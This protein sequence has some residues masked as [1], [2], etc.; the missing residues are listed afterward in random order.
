MSEL[1]SHAALDV[2]TV[3]EA[4]AMFVACE[5]GPLEEVTQFTRQVAGA[6]LNVAIGLSRLGLKVG[7]ASRVGDDVCSG[8][9]YKQLEKNRS[10][11]YQVAVGNRCSTGDQLK[12]K[13]S[14][15]SDPR[16]E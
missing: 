16:L 10:N 13:E 14:E 8:F 11:G 2:V 6:E 3:G 1:S 12:S 7:W 9:V 15:A 5:T 4:M